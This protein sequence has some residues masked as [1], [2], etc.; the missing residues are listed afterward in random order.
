MTKRA[1]RTL[2]SLLLFV[3]V[4]IIGATFYFQYAKGLQP[5]PLCI[6]QRLC[7]FLFAMFCM[8]GMCLSTLRRGRV[9]ALFQVFFAFV[10]FLFADRQLWLQFFPAEQASA[11]LPGFDVM[12]K[13]LP[14]QDILHGLLWGAGECAE[15]TWKW[16]GLSMP[17]WAAIY[18]LA[19]TV[20]SGLVFLLL[21][22]SLRVITT[23]N[24]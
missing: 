20:V 9:V 15:V 22:K 18:F 19:M 17:A 5:C 24:N 11:C 13:Y 3:S 6:M 2:Q 12:I 10:G 8:M 23:S 4:L 14:W 1:Y 7:A 16:L 21:G